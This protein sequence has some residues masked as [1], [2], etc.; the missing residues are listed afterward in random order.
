MM[1]EAIGQVSSA[2]SCSGSRC[3]STADGPGIPAAKL[4]GGGISGLV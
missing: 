4:I 2:C 3:P 1:G